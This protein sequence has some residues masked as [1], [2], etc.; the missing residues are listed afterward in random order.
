MNAV[1][2]DVLLSVP[3][4]ADYLSLLKTKPAT[5]KVICGLLDKGNTVALYPGGIHEQ[6]R[7]DE[8]AEK[9]FFPANLSF[10][11]IAIQKGVDL[12]PCYLF[13]ENQLWPTS[14]SY[15]NF[16]KWFYSKT[17]VGNILLHSPLLPVP[18]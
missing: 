9:F 1:V 15:I 16:N 3:V 12:V 11:R 14:E 8:T 10:V 4:V 13:G 17:G 7:T 6:V 2:A 5:E 18:T